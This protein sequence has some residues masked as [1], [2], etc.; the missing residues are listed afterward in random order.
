MKILGKKKID[1]PVKVLFDMSLKSNSG[2]NIKVGNKTY[3]I[4]LDSDGL[5]LIKDFVP[6][7]K[8]TKKEFKKYQK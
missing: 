2:V 7:F 4:V 8:L 6:E 5:F 3:N 1:L